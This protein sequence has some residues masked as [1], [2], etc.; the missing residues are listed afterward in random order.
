LFRLDKENSMVCLLS[1]TANGA[2]TTIQ[3]A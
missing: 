2:Q 3:E 1:R